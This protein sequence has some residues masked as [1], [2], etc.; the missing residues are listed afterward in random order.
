MLAQVVAM[1]GGEDDDGFVPQ[2]FFLQFV[3]HEPNLGV[4][5]GHAGMVGLHVLASQSVVFLAELE[6]KGH[7]S[8]DKGQG[9]HV[10]QVVQGVGVVADS[11]GR[12]ELEVFV[13]S[14]K[15][16]VRFLYAA[17]DE[18]RLLFVRFALVQPLNHLAGVLAVLVLFVPEPAGTMP[19]RGLGSQGT[20]NLHP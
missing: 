18:E 5:E 20:T 1:I 11:L 12:V 2:F 15:G 9:R 6:T 17:Y 16:H 10:D 4:D 3:Q 14:E 13:R 8:F 7:G 19:G